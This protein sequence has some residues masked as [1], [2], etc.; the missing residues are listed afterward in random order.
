MEKKVVAI[1]TKGNC[2]RFFASEDCTGKFIEILPRSPSHHY[3]GNWGFNN[4]TVSVGPC[5]DQCGVNITGPVPTEDG[6]N[7]T[8]FDRPFYRGRNKKNQYN[9]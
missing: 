6:L 7:V 5:Q 4:V 1:N 8:L 3:L 2:A 9:L